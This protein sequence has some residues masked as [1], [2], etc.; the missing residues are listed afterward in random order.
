MSA[1]IY[2]IA[3]KADVSTATVSRVFNDKSEVAPATESRVLEV[4]RQLDYQPHASAQSLAR[5]ET[6]LI[7]A[8]VPVLANPFYMGVLRGM[9]EALSTAEYDLLVYTPSQPENVAEQVRRASQRGRSDGLIFL[10][11]SV[12]L[13]IEEIL[14]ASD[15]EVVLVD[16]THPEFESIALDNEKGGYEAT[17]YLLDQGYRRIAHVTT[18]DPEPPPATDRRKGYERALREHGSQEPIIARGKEEPFAFEREGGV[19]AMRTLLDTDRVP[20]AVFAASDML[21]IGCLEVLE[22]AGLEVPE[23]VALM[24]FDDVEISAYVGLTTLRQPIRDFGKLAVEKLTRR[25]DDPD[26]AVSSTI[27]APELVPRRTCGEQTENGSA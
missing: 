11:S 25:I 13:E 15:Q 2:D 5:D 24:G 7:A 3:E 9:Q 20:D 14:G 22:D 26:R 23:D 1:T 16:T 27:F 4:A 18:E 10:S 19:A 12:T 6:K 17:R 21:A 8:V